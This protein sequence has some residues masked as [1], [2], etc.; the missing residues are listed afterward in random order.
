MTGRIAPRAA[1]LSCALCLAAAL[2]SLGCPDATVSPNLLLITLD[3]TRADRL[4]PYGGPASTPSLAEFATGAVVYERAYS[5]SSWTLPSHASIFTGLLPM[6]HGAQAAA[7]H[8][9]KQHG[10]RPLAPQFETLAERLHGAGYR[11][12]AVVG[13]PVLARGFGVAQGFERYDDAFSGPLQQ[14]VGRRADAV[15]AR[16]V[17]V[18]RAFEPEPFFLFVNFFDPHAPYR[19]PPPHD[20]GVPSNDAARAAPLIAKFRAREPPRPT[21]DLGEAERAALD[22]ML[23]GYDAEIAYMDRALG[24]LIRAAE[25]ASR[26]GGLFVAITGDHGESFGEHWFTL[27][28]VHV[29]EDATRVP[30]LVRHPDVRGASTRISEP[31]QNHRLFSTV[32]AA[33][34]VEPSPGDPPPLDGPAIPV[35]TS[36]QRSDTAI[37][38]YGGGV[39]RD[40]RAIYDPP[41]KL[42]AS[43]RGAFELYDLERD[44]EELRDLSR[45]R[46]EKARELALQ[47]REVERAHPPR[48]DPAL[49]AEVDDETRERLRSLGYG[50]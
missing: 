17:E 9:S 13:G 22:A 15:A 25:E 28:G 23:A 36:V 45:E 26:R 33:A 24:R 30:L 11:T 35:V 43:S 1:A 21:G 8:A 31:V 32:L 14:F 4:G 47:L 3:T 41:Y 40:L 16:A 42:V 34:G 38:A 46:P 27:H 48:F 29:Y 50:D 18:M 44:P 6:E 12:G 10:S 49:R 37:A 7:A 2:A 20:A 39:D 19:P 5:T